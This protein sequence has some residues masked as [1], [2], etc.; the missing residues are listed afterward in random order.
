MQGGE[1]FDHGKEPNWR[2]ESP[3][4]LCQV[5][6]EQYPEPRTCLAMVDAQ[7]CYLGHPA[8]CRWLID[9][10]IDTERRALDAALDENDT[11]ESETHWGVS[12]T[13][14]G[15]TQHRGSAAQCN[16]PDCADAALDGAE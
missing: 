16:A 1:P 13:H 7:H 14:G 12:P 15:L 5:T 10:M 3:H 9:A 8:N 4:P 11:G 6:R 2:D